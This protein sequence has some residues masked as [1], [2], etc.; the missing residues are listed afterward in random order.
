[1]RPAPVG[2]AG[3]ASARVAY[4]E[5]RAAPTWTRLAASAGWISHRQIEREARRE[6][7][8]SPLV[9]ALARRRLVVAHQRAER[10][11]LGE[12]VRDVGLGQRLGQQHRIRGF[13][14]EEPR[15]DF[16]TGV[17]DSVPRSSLQPRR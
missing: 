14:V 10:G 13:S 12:L 16:A 17:V 1:V 9:E 2:Q 11:A 4:S 15:Q 6:K 3:R 5:P 8:T 7:A